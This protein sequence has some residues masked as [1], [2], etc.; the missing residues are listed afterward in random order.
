[1]QGDAECCLGSDDMAFSKDVADYSFT[2]YVR[3]IGAIKADAQLIAVLD[4]SLGI[5]N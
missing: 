5:L 3:V 4:G 2:G 1:M